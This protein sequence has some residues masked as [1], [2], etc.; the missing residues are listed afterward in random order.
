M[1]LLDIMNGGQR[2]LFKNGFSDRG[3]G[4]LM[5]GLIWMGSFENMLAQVEEKLSQGFTTLKM[6]VGAIDF[7]QECRILEAVRSR[8]DPNAI[9]LRVD[10]NGAFTAENAH[11]RLERLGAFGLHSI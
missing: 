3:E 5:N 9:T 7:E 6:K 1:A 8:F 2:M 4:I 11:E 10:A